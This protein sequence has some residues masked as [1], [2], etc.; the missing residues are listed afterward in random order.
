MGLFDD[1]E[2]HYPLPTEPPEFIKSGERR[3]QTKDLPDPYLRKAVI[4]EDGRL[5][6][7]GE[8]WSDFHGD[9]E[10]YT[11]NWVSIKGGEVFTRDGEDL[12]SV[13]YVAR[14]TEGKVSKII[15]TERRREPAKKFEKPW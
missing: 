12:E 10:F 11:S 6:V 8:E 9:L 2:C 14:F 4:T 13:T 1:V 15:E 3:F 7:D 5:E